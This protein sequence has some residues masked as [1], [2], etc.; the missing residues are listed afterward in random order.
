MSI[1][2]C[3]KLIHLNL[4]YLSKAVTDTV[5]DAIT[6]GCSQLQTLQVAGSEI[7]DLGI[8][9]I[10]KNCPSIATLNVSDNRF[11]ETCIKYKP[12]SLRA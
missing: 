9:Y 1:G 10:A 3:K 4:D 2:N 11:A 6:K 7:T 12:I 5:L 8:T